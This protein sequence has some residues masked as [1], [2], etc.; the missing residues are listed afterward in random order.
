MTLK[1]IH[2]NINFNH[3]RLPITIEVLHSGFHLHAVINGILVSVL[4]IGHSLRDSVKAL[5]ER[6]SMEVICRGK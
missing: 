3:H 1:V 5:K 2:K 6:C 4:C